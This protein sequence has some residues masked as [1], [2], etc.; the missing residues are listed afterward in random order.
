LFNTPSFELCVETLNTRGVEGKDG[1]VTFHVRRQGMKPPDGFIPTRR[2][3]A[4]PIYRPTAGRINTSTRAG[5]SRP[6]PHCFWY[7]GFRNFLVLL[8]FFFFHWHFSGSVVFLLVFIF[9]IK[10]MN[11][12]L[13][14]WIRTNYKLDFFILNKF[15]IRTFRRLNIFSGENFKSEHICTKRVLNVGTWRARS[16]Y[17]RCRYKI[18]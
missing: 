10:F 12:F 15:Q 8:F 6:R 17:I 18:D 7:S 5:A 4:K 1:L 16:M 11:I 2:Q 9:W 3:A 13:I 14:F